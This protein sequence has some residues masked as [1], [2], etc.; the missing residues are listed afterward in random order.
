MERMLN[1]KLGIADIRDLYGA[2]TDIDLLRE[3]ESA[4]VFG[5]F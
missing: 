5:E 2:Y 4:K 1:L 3:L